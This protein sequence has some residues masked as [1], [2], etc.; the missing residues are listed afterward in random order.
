[1]GA[2]KHFP[3]SQSFSHTK[4]VSRCGAGGIYDQDD[5]A[6]CPV[7]YRGKAY[8]GNSIW[9][10]SSL[11]ACQA[12]QNC[13]VSSTF[14]DPQF[15][16]PMGCS[17]ITAQAITTRGTSQATVIAPSAGNGWRGTV[18]LDD[19]GGEAGAH[20]FD[21]RVTLTCVGGERSA[22]QVPVRLSCT[23]NVGTDSCHM[24]R[25]E[26]F[27]P[28]AVHI[29]SS[30]R[31][32]WGTVCGHWVWDNDNAADIVCRQLGYSSGEIYTYGRTSQL[33]TLPI[34]AGGRLCA[35]TEANIFACP[36]GA[37]LFQ[38]PDCLNG[39]VGPD[40]VQGTLDDSPDPACSHSVD[41]GAICHNAD[42]P[43]N[44]NPS[45]PRGMCRAL[46]SCKP[47]VSCSHLFPQSNSVPYV[48][49][50]RW[51]RLRRGWL[52]G[53]QRPAGALQLH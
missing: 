49:M 36:Q 46:R 5:I 13:A 17:Q 7:R 28:Q 32:S 24:G 30:V 29:G 41:Q 4:L 43:S 12:G 37:W 35:G 51:L 23:H 3:L 34:V 18:H 25:I 14:T 48:W 50:I 38:D 9:D 10:I 42:S 26:V 20:V 16:V 8:V 27:N 40:G 45:A 39:C 33:P 44:M 1:V 11:G 2:N 47:T 19:A 52:H 21:V 15:R 6:S 31:G 22:P 53:Q